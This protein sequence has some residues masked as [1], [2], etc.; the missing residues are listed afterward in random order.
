LGNSSGYKAL[1]KREESKLTTESNTV[2][3]SEGDT[4][5]VSISRVGQ[6]ITAT[7]TSGTKTF[8]KEYLDVKLN[9]VDSNY[10]YL[11]LF[12]NRNIIAEFSDISFE[13]TGDAGNA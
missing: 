6:K 3:V 7:F 12:A 4:Y 2:T 8:T 9:S 10:M 11:C 5:T 13:I 1:F